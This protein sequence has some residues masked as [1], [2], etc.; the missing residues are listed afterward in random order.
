MIRCPKCYYDEHY[1]T[2]KQGVWCCARCKTMFEETEG[3][4]SQKKYIDE[5]VIYIQ[6]DTVMDKIEKYKSGI[7]SNDEVYSIIFKMVKLLRDTIKE[8]DGKDEL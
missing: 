4:I 3:L 6:T 2:D 7:I 8:K 1:P 5:E